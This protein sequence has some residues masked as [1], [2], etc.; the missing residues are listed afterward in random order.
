MTGITISSK[1]VEIAKRL[2][3]TA[4][5]K[6]ASTTSAGDSGDFTVLGKGQVKF[7]EL[8]AEKMGEHFRESDEKGDFDVVWISEA[9]SHFPNKPL[10]FQN[11]EMVLK[12][13]GKLVL[14][15][16]FKSMDVK[17]GDADIKA[18]EGE[19]SASASPQTSELML[20]M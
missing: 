19:L 1:Q 20:L 2:T 3:K 18:I 6:E 4:A 12:K 11:A 13:G 14:A 16:W 5:S 15:D 9:L 10:F 7:L 8:D 17:A